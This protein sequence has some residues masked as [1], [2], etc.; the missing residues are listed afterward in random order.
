MLKSSENNHPGSGGKKTKVDMIADGILKLHVCEEC[1][2]EQILNEMSYITIRSIGE[3]K[4]DSFTNMD[5][6]IKNLAHAISIVNV[7]E[8]KIEVIKASIVN[9]VMK[10]IDDK[11]G[12][13]AGESL[14]D[15]VAMFLSGEYCGCGDEVCFSSD[16]DSRD[17]KKGNETDNYIQ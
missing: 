12:E 2:S 10:G 7:A 6:D 13:G 4:E 14:M 8:Q 9:H 11:C 3:T 1:G 17:K 15:A 5:I 16:K